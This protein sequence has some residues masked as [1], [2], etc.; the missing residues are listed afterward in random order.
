M[1]N[2]FPYVGKEVIVTQDMCDFNGHMNVN[3]IKAVFEQGWEFTSEDF[4]FN[5]EYLQSGFSSFTL[6]DNYRFQK[7]FLL[8]DKIFPAFRLL[9]VNTK[10]FHMIGA[11]FDKDGTI[12]AMYETVEGHIDMSKRRMSP[13][14]PERLERVLAIKKAHDAQGPVPYNVRLHIKDL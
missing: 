12:C 14:D 11:L 2:L 1:N 9:N 8:G 7:E 3:H 13:M 4:G 10:L 6:E 5:D